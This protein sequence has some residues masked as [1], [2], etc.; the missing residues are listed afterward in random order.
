MEAHRTHGYVLRPSPIFK[1]VS[2]TMHYLQRFVRVALFT[3]LDTLRQAMHLYT[4]LSWLSTCKHLEPRKA[5]IDDP[6]LPTE[7]ACSSLSYGQVHQGKAG[8]RPQEYAMLLV[9]LVGKWRQTFGRECWPEHNNCH[10]TSCLLRLSS[11]SEQNGISTNEG[12]IHQNDHVPPSSC[13]L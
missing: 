7:S 5:A 10:H 11:P 13:G 9:P 8:G 12:A 1:E 3:T 4:N 6:A 2:F